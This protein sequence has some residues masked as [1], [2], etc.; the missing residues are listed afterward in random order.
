MLKLYRQFL[1]FALS[2]FIFCCGHLYANTTYFSKVE[3]EN[4]QLVGKILYTYWFWDVYYAALYAPT[5]DFSWRNSFFLKLT[6]LRDFS[7]Q[8]IIEETIDQM[9]SQTPKNNNDD[10]KRW[11]K[12]LTV[13]FPDIKENQS[14]IGYFDGKQRTLFFTGQ[15]KYL[16]Q[17]DSLAFSRSFFAIWLSDQSENLE[18]SRQLRGLK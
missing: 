9:S 12:Q 4:P 14:L 16:G 17:I 11:Q 18:L 3:K 1:L 2:S 6:Y 15:G 10:L 13:I 5:K 7:A 8:S